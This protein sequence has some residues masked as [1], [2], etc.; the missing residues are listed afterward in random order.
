MAEDKTNQ[1][2]TGRFKEQHMV[3]PI[4]TS[5]RQH[6]EQQVTSCHWSESKTDTPWH[7]ARNLSLTMD[8]ASPPSGG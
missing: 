1:N 7:Q 5:S 6:Q 2:P 8:S 3:H 4:L